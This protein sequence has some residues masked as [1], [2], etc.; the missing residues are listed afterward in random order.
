LAAAAAQSRDADGLHISL[1]GNH[2]LWL[3]DTAPD[4]PLAVAIPLDGDFPLRAAGALRLHRLITTKNAGPIPQSQALTSQQ[5]KRL[6]QMLLAL[7]GHFSQA[8]YREIASALF[9]PSVTT[10]K[11]WKTHPIRA[12]TIRLVN[13]AIKMVNRGYLKLLRG[14]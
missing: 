9:G 10:E 7:D 14:R 1:P 4:Q 13:D 8:S 6:T 3:L 12:R 11:G 5:R 2:Q